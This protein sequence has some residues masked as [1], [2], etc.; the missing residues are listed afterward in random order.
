MP[1]STW[2]AEADS[3]PLLDGVRQI[4]APGVPGPL[5]V[6]TARA[7]PVVVGRLGGERQAA[8]IAAGRIEKGRVVA[9]GHT[10]YFDGPT[11]DAA[12]TGVLVANAVRWASGRAGRKG[13]AVRVAAIR[14]PAL[15]AF[16]KKADFAAQEVDGKKLLGG[17]ESFDVV[18]LD[19]NETADPPLAEALLRF[20]QGGKGV[21]MTSLGWGWLQLHPGKTLVADHPGN[22]FLARAGIAWADGYLERTAPSGF[23]AAEI[24]PLVHAGQALDALIDQR[25]GRRKLDAKELGQA[26]LTLELTV[27]TLPHGP[28]A[29]TGALR[30]LGSKTAI[31]MVPRPKKPLT[32]ELALERILLTAQLAENERL[33]PEKVCAHPAAAVFPGSVP[34]GAERVRRGVSIDTKV[35]GWHSTGLY[36]AAGE[37]IEV[38]LPSEA[39]GK[40]LAVRIGCHSDGLWGLSQWRRVPAICTQRPLTQPDVRIASAFGGLVYIDVPQRC[41]LGRIDAAVRG[42]VEAPYFVFG[43]TSKEEW[44][45]TIRQRPAPWAE[46]ATDRVIVS[47]PS[48]VVRSLDNP[49]E[50]LDVWDKIL[51]ACADL[52]ARPVQRERPERYVA[53]EQISA[54][55]MHAGYPIMTHLDAAESMASKERLLAGNWGLFH[56]MGHNHQSGD[57]TF[58]GAGE[59]T[60]NLFSLYVCETVCRLKGPGHPAV[61]MGETRDKAYRKY[62]ATGPD[63]KKWQADPF[64]AL[65]MY[66]QLREGFGWEA[67]RKVFDEYRKLPAAERPKNDEEKRDQWLVRFSRTVNRNLG[68]FFQAWGVP[69]SQS[70]RKSIAH[71]PAWMPEGFPPKDFR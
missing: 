68:P 15:A 22:R 27:R 51:D 14:R 43:T 9:F 5:C 70:A 16:L 44:R 7:F 69:T 31:D 55:Y 49:E 21:L 32:A 2:G 56:E 61:S 10:G 71:L 24:S 36:A 40:G 65:T 8:V 12:E 11:L 13:A 35:P 30:R 42:A 57:W 33:P 29:I 18:C 45:K 59:V 64:L 50:V 6:A 20:V 34:K 39:A 37:V 25:R 52:A 1:A 3:A 62:A 58:A 19:A 23:A 63:F 41:A 28:G 66:V 54:G 38:K 17:L 46:L 4:A 26:S 48:G 53:D 47:V 60:C 67:Y